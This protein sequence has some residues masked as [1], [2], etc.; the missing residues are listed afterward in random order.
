MGF[1]SFKIEIAESDISWGVIEA[2]HFGLGYVW[3][4][5]P[6]NIVLYLQGA[7]STSFA[8]VLARGEMGPVFTG[9]VAP[10]KEI[11][12]IFVVAAI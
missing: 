11:I 8:K 6:S 3:Q 4:T 7:Q 10:C 12:S 1:C 2:R 9:K 5:K